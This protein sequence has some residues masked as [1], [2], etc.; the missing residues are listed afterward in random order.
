MTRP[1]Y[2]GWKLWPVQRMIVKVLSGIELDNK[3]RDIPIYDYK[4]ETKQYEFTEAEFADFAHEE[5]RLS[6]N[7]QSQPDPKG[8]RWCM[9]LGRRSFKSALGA[10]V[11]GLGFLRFAR[12]SDPFEHYGL[13]PGTKVMGALFSASLEQ[14]DIPFSDVKNDFMRVK[15]FDA[16]NPRMKIRSISFKHPSE[17]QKYGKKAGI[18]YRIQPKAANSKL[19]LGFA[20]YVLVFDEIG[21]WITES[22]SMSPEETIKQVSPTASSFGTDAFWMAMSNATRSMETYWREL[23]DQAMA[24]PGEPY[25]VF[26]FPSWWVNLNPMYVHERVIAYKADPNDFAVQY[27]SE[28][29]LGGKQWV[30]TEVLGRSRIVH[31]RTHAPYFFLG[32]DAGFVGDYFSASVIAPIDAQNIRV[33]EHFSLHAGVGD[34]KDQPIVPPLDAVRRLEEWHRKY[35][36]QQG[37]ID[38]A[39]ATTLL[40]M[41]SYP[42]FQRMRDI[43]YTNKINLVAYLMLYEWLAR[44]AIEIQDEGLI[45]NLGGLVDNH[46]KTGRKIMAKSGQHD[47][48]SDSL[49]RALLAMVYF[50]RKN[51]GL[52]G[53]LHYNLESF[54]TYGRFGDF[55]GSKFIDSQA[56]SYQAS[57]QERLMGSRAQ[58]VFLPRGQG[59]Q[60][61]PG[62]DA[63][64]VGWG[65]GHNQRIYNNPR[66]PGNPRRR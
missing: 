31:A 16:Y 55:L 35:N 56:R 29:G 33:V 62:T 59:S 61:Q 24:E 4:L 5:G 19:G 14:A 44:G 18:T 17:L 58:D 57:R 52:R 66:S 2:A 26:R 12:I 3:V 39:E 22:G 1:D 64:P 15:M 11:Q 37:L 34:Y 8:K 10:A 21:N 30:S 43:H 20:C 46:R 60:D 49:C 36:F 32:V 51:P 42:L 23:C 65:S 7:S 47:D 38:Q 25:H 48:A 63:S 28:F 6:F 54:E 45:T 9:C 27:G 13:R 50:I 41:F 40:S 53:I